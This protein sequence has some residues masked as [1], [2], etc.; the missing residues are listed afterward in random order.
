MAPEAISEHLISK[1]FLGEH[2]PRPPSLASLLLTNAYLHIRHQCNPPSKNPCYGPDLLFLY[3]SFY[4]WT[5]LH[6]A[7]R[8]GYKKTVKLL[9]KKGAAPDIR[10][11]EEVRRLY[12]L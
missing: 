9:V 1:N 5:P 8:R 3:F 7:V 4:Q 10:D 12:S 6:L 11:K 2:P